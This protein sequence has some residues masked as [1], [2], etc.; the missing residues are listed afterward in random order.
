MSPKVG[1][2]P[3]RR[4]QIILAAK[5][6]M[7]QYGFGHFSIKDVAESATLSTGV[8]YHYFKN[9]QDLLVQVL[10]ESFSD[11]EETVREAVEK[12]TAFEGK[13]KS[14]LEAV[15]DVPKQNPDFYLILLNYIAQSPYNEE[16]QPLITKFF[17]HLRTFLEE[18][19]EEGVEQDIL[20]PETKP[21]LSHL[22]MSQA[23]GLAFQEQLL[24]LDNV[25]YLREEFVRLFQKYIE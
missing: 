21:V 8:I 20:H 18:I 6:C 7:L 15:A 19:L 9:K 22:V 5:D 12:H 24:P 13:F 17:D 4:Q 11:T 10:K 16:V 23:M 25:E 3:L 1:M 14:Y 2:E